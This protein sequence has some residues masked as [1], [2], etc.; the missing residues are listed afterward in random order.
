MANK[1]EVAGFHGPLFFH[2][3]TEELGKAFERAGIPCT[4]RPD[5]RSSIW[6]KFGVF[7]GLVG[8]ESAARLPAGPV[9]DHPETRELMRGILLE[10]GAVAKATG[11]E[12]R[13]DYADYMMGMVD[14]HVPGTHKGSMLVDLQAGRRL[15]LEAINGELVRLGREHGVPTPLSY[16]VYA[17]LCP[18]AN[19]T[20]EMPV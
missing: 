5:I 19:G 14:E 1:V 18:F 3:R 11:V 20:P 2:K 17:L 7:V 13:T 10:T 8:V 16:A 15:E 9:W 6:E 4:V 12:L